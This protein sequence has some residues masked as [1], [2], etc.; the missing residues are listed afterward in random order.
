MP[1]LHWIFL[2]LVLS[3]FLP[4]N[5]D[6]PARRIPYATYG[7]IAANVVI[8]FFCVVIANVYLGADHIRA[9]HDVE[10]LLQAGRDQLSP[11]G[12]EL[13]DN[14][15]AYEK[16]RAAGQVPVNEASSLEQSAAKARQS[17][18]LQI[19]AREVGTAAGYERFWRIQ[20]LG[21]E[22]VWE[23]HYATLNTFAY[24]VSEPSVARKVLGLFG[25]MFLHGGIMHLLGNML[26]LWVFGRAV[27]D[28][29]GSALTLGAYIVCGLAATLLHHAITLAFAPQTAGVPLMGA[30]G[31][32][33]GVLGLFALR[34]YRT[35][36]RIFYILPT[37]V[38]VLGAG[39]LLGGGLLGL[40]LGNMS[41]GLVAGFLISV[42]L[43]I[44]FGRTWAW[45]SFKP[46]SMYAIGVWI[47]A[48]NLL[49]ALFELITD[50][51]GGVAYWAH[52][53]GFLCGLGYAALIGFR[54]EGER[55]YLL[56]DAQKQ[57][58]A[59]DMARA[60]AFAQNL[61]DREPH[62]AA[63]REVLARAFDDNGN[64]AGALDNYER[65]IALY[66]KS[67]QRAQA[68]GAYRAALERHPRFILPPGQQF[69]IASQMARDQE[70]QSA[71]ENYF[72]IPYTFPDAPEGETSLLRAAHI[73]GARL[74]RFD[75]VRQLMTTFLERYPDSLWREQ[76][77]RLREGA[78]RSEVI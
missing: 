26:F 59:G 66:L 60:I 39:T 36:V 24:R 15:E 64:E 17:L 16:A 65:A 71:A 10:Q 46:A 34:F 73:Y 1:L 50:E 61:A 54:D 8:F 28:A 49:P 62:N 13:L 43:L 11:Q 19:A 74:Q 12:R 7:L 72:K 35:P 45:G 22:V 78:E 55:E 4:Y 3:F 56:Q 68:A 40:L 58:Q 29:L 18:A 53:G 27:E 20:H 9:R 37:V 33:A 14:L 32:I 69:A 52:V 5:V 42:G 44:A 41:T 2:L 70:W 57:L 38:P 23:P 25:S 67:G 21:D 6:R 77:E 47:V 63:A 48:F 31:A 30:S 51:G 75:L 76:A